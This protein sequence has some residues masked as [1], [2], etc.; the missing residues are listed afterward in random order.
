MMYAFPPRFMVSVMYVFLNRLFTHEDKVRLKKIY[1]YKKYILRI[2]LK[3][4]KYIKYI[5]CKF[6][7]YIKN[8][9][10]LKNS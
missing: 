4:T 9:I 8:T 3:Y 5:R 2:Y 7:R 1:L 6:I 10:L